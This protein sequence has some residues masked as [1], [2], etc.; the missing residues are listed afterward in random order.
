MQLHT[1]IATILKFNEAFGIQHLSLHVAIY[2]SFKLLI[3]IISFP[4]ISKQLRKKYIQFTVKNVFLATDP[5]LFDAMQVYSP[6]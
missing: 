3:L 6:C 4:N 5:T 1:Q 2:K